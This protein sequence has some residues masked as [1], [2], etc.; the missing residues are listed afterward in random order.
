MFLI[1]F[2]N[3]RN[4]SKIDLFIPLK[5]QIFISVKKIKLLVGQNNIPFF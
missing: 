2:I 3:I 1:Y 4:G 5:K